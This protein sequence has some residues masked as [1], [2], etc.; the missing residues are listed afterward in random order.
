MHVDAFPYGPVKIVSDGNAHVRIPGNASTQ[1]NFRSGSEKIR[2]K[3]PDSSQTLQESEYTLTLGSGEIGMTLEA[4]GAIYFSAQESWDEYEDPGDY[5]QF[6]EDFGDQIAEQIEAQFDEQMEIMNRQLNEQFERLSKTYSNTGLS[7]EEMDRILDQA[8]IK[9]ER[10]NV[11][12]QEAMRR[13]QERAVQKMETARR[14]KELKAEAARRRGRSRKPWSMKV[15]PP[16]PPP[17]N[18]P[19]SEE[20]RLMILRMLE[21]KKIS[22]E[23]ADELLSALE[24]KQE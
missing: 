22:L 18:D 6:P 8:R 10:A 19:V 23:E 7:E 4:A 24:G 20:E 5:A 1:I 13:A 15:P 12:A 21:Q 16:P 17:A 2:I 14:R 3:L 9:S 11:R